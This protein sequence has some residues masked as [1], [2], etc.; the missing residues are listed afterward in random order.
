MKIKNNLT[1]AD[2]QPKLDRLWQLSG[3]KINLLNA[4][5]DPAKGSP[6]FTV[7]GQYTTRGWAK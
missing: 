5:Y 4:Q 2:L 1:A 6:V 3:E 7:K